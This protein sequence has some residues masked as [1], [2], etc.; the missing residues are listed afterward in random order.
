VTW[1]TVL[2][3]PVVP[4]GRA[5]TSNFFLHT[6]HR[7]DVPCC[8]CLLPALASLT[9]AAPRPLMSIWS[10]CRRVVLL[11]RVG[12]VSPD[13]AFASLSCPVAL[14]TDTRRASN[15]FLFL[16]SL[17]ALRIM[18]SNRVNIPNQYLPVSPSR[19]ASMLV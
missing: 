7:G 9:R 3:C 5:F 6:G 16:S 10:A 12:L 18:S 1:P 11:S 15:P 19:F 17:S 8:A 4:Y 14:T 2:L 13:T